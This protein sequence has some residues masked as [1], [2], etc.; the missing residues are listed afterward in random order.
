MSEEDKKEEEPKIISRPKISQ[1]QKK[2]KNKKV[3]EKD[4][5]VVDS[6]T[7]LGAPSVCPLKI[8]SVEWVQPMRRRS[9]RIRRSKNK[10]RQILATPL[11]I[12]SQVEDLKDS[13]SPKVSKE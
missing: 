13:P 7:Y 1:Q 6:L 4:K 8:T 12:T 2:D 10:K 9:N 3:D 11:S 5:E